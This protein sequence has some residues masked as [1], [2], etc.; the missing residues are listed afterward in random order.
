MMLSFFLAKVINMLY[1]YCV[2]N[3]GETC[4]LPFKNTYIAGDHKGRPYENKYG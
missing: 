3:V 2:F 1:N 4:G